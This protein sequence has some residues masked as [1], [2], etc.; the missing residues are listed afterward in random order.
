[1]ATNPDPTLRMR[2]TALTKD[3]H[4]IKKLDASALDWMKHITEFPSS[5]AVTIIDF[6][7]TIIVRLNQYYCNI[8]REKNSYNVNNYGK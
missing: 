3:R 2:T 7:I 5:R 6:Q 8:Y 4:T 1:M